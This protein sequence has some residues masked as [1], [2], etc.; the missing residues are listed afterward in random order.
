[1]AGHGRFFGAQAEAGGVHRRHLGHPFT[2]SIH[3]CKPDSRPRSAVDGHHPSG[4]RAVRRPAG[5]DGPHH[6]QQQDSEGE[7]SF[8]FVAGVDWTTQ[9]SRLLL[10]GCHTGFSAAS[11]QNQSCHD[12]KMV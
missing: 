5:T 12:R 4:V 6:G 1:M 10:A 7:M 9:D 2:Q 8:S 3:E 11:L